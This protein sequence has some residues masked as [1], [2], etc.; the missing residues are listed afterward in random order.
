MPILDGYVAMAFGFNRDGFSEGGESRRNRIRRVIDALAAFLTEH[1]DQMIELR[2]TARAAVR[3]IDVASDLR[4]LDIVIWCSQDD[5]LERA[6]KMRNAWLDAP[7]RAYEPDP[8][9]SIP[10]TAGGG[11]NR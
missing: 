4:L 3:D 2:E 1:R 10:V 6:G 11:Q 9:T 7:H 5:L 8:V